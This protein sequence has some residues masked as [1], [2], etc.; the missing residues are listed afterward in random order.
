MQALPAQGGGR[1]NSVA[2]EV[3]VPPASTCQLSL[4]A[5]KL[6]RAIA[7]VEYHSF[8]C[9]QCPWAK[10]LPM[11]SHEHHQ[12]SARR[13]RNCHGWSAG[14]DKRCAR[15]CHEVPHIKL[16]QLRVPTLISPTR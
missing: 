3:L 5:H 14:L 8:I 16:Q 12:Q 10:H 6:R 4:S 1:S 9:A 2:G 11:Q 13:P 15:P 7:Q